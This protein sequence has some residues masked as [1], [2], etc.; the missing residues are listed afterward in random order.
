MGDGLDSDQLWLDLLGEPDA[1]G[2]DVPMTC[3]MC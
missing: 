3:C 1:R 2:H